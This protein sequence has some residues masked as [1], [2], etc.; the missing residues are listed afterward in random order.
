[1][2]RL[3][4]NVMFPDLFEFI[5]KQWRDILKIINITLILIVL[6]AVKSHYKGFKNQ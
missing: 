1:M 4:K 5:S 2:T 3:K 6:S